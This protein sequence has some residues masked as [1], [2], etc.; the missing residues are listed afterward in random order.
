MT[1]PGQS[2]AENPSNRKR[3]AKTFVDAELS[4][5]ST[6]VGHSDTVAAAARLQAAL[7]ARSPLI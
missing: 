7:K 5:V 3:K 1:R 2:P 6:D 4:K